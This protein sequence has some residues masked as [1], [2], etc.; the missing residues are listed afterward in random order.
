[1]NMKSTILTT[2]GILLGGLVLLSGQALAYKGD[3]AVQGP[4]YSQERHE[5]M[6]DAFESNDYA[7]W[8]ELMGNKGRVTQLINEEN[9]SLFA[10]AHKLALEGKTDEAKAIREELG[11]GLRNGKGNDMGKG[12]CTR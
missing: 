4:Y 5:A 6:T 10:E 2:S 8:K 9:F 1:M 7:S 12:G 3:P 11:L